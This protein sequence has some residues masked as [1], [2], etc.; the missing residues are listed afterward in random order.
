[1]DEWQME[2]E[3]PDNNNDDNGRL[4]RLMNKNNDGLNGKGTCIYIC[5]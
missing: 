4:M 1:M 5:V 2:E 3:D